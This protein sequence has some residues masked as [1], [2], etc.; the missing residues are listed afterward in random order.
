MIGKVYID[1][2]DTSDIYATYGLSLIEESYPSLI[3]WPRLKKVEVV[4]W[5][6]HSGT[7][8]DLSNPV[9]DS[10]EC[11]L[12]FAGTTTRAK[13]DAFLAIFST[14]GAYHTFTTAIGRTYRLRLV[15]GAPPRWVGSMCIIDL[16]FAD[17]FPLSNYT[18][19]APTSTIAASDDYLLDGVKFSDYGVRILEDSS[20]QLTQTPATKVNLVRSFAS[21]A[22][23]EYD[24]TNVTYDGYNARLSCLMRAATLDE[25]WQNYDALL[26]DITRPEARYITGKNEGKIFPCYYDS[27]RVSSFYPDGKIWM[28]FDIAVNVFDTPTNI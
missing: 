2:K 3:Q 15:K 1:N 8:P 25:L 11:T 23:V 21:K 4:S 17:D 22:G 24:S 10:R 12:R 16:R 19:E 13:V 27:S 14:G 20:A 28:E 6:E 5:Q 7:E 9:L 18:Y 26:Y